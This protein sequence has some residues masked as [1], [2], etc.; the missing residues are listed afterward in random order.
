MYQNTIGS[1]S[2]TYT[3]SQGLIVTISVVRS[4]RNQFL[5]C[6]YSSDYMRHSLAEH[7]HAIIT[8]VKVRACVINSGWGS[9]YIRGVC[10]G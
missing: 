7:T 9:L 4:G 8:D 10:P 1:T 3:P 2:S 5:S 6:Y